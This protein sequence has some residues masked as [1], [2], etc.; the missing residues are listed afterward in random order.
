MKTSRITFT[1]FY[2]LEVLFLL[3]FILTTNL[4]FAQTTNE[5][6]DNNA[7]RSTELN[8]PTG[9]NFEN[10]KL[11]QLDISALNDL[12]G[13]LANTL[14]RIYLVIK[15]TE[16]SQVVELSMLGIGRTDETGWFVKQI[17]IPAHYNE[18][19]I[20]L[21]T[22]EIENQRYVTLSDSDSVQV[23]F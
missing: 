8:V 12:G 10:H 5:P 2:S 20:E 9:F 4:A 23:S 19:M 17:E 11:L 1:Q 14:V 21:D 16:E 18:L 13:P 15:E 7:T 22:V 6:E 3:L